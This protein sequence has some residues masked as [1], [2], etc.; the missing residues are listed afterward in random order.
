MNPAVKAKIDQIF[1]ARQEW[2]KKGPI[3][4]ASEAQIERV[5]QWF[6]AHHEGTLPEGLAEFWRTTNGIDLYGHV[7]W[8][9]DRGNRISGIV[10]VNELYIE[11]FTDQFFV[12]KQDDITMYSYHPASGKFRELVMFDL[13]T[14]DAEYDTFDDLADKVLTDAMWGARL[15]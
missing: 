1:Q 4:P 14:V 12:G 10:D 6:A 13:D 7:L 15:L 5:A 8:A 2:W 11:E 9:T 3:P